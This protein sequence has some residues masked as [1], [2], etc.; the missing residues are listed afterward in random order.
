MKKIVRVVIIVLVVAL[1][2]GAGGLFILPRLTTASAQSSSQN[3][4]TSAATTSDL[5]N[6]VSGT[7]NVRPQQTAL[8][9][10]QTSGSIASV[11]VKQGDTVASGTVLSTLGQAS[12][13]V[14]VFNAQVDLSTAEKDLET[15]LDNT[16]VRADA[17]AALAQAEIDLKTAQDNS[18]AMEF[19]VASQSTIDIAQA[20]LISAQ[21]ALKKAEDNYTK[22][23]HTNT[24]SSDYKMRYANALSQLASA[25]QTVAAAENNL[26][27]LENLPNLRNVALVNA[28]LD[29][30]KA[31]YLE[32]KQA[33]DLVKDG[34]NP[35]TVAAAQAKVA[36]AQAIVNEAQVTAPFAGTITDVYA[37]TGSLVSASTNAFRIQDLSQYLIDVSVSEVDITSVQIG[38]PATITFDAISDKTYTGKVTGIASTG[39]SSSGAVNY[40]VTVAIDNPDSA[41]K[42]GM[43]ASVDIVVKQL[44]GVLVVPNAALTTLNNERVVYV[45]Q[46]NTPVAVPVT[47]G[48][49]SDTTSQVVSG[50]L[51]E[52]D[53]I[54]TNPTSVTTTTTTTTSSGGLFG[55]LLGGLFGGGGVT[56][57]GPSGG[58]GGAPPSGGFP[59]GGPSGSSGGNSS[60]GGN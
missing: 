34:P 19:Q 42:A 23:T 36:A 43:S 12:L 31:T 27:Y 38:N 56:G 57:G 6:T 60:S 15:I 3:Y 39:T 7:G 20:S 25:R 53:L 37:Q 51:K 46:N 41:I 52:G 32:A 9:T 33:W 50:N 13:P 14:A 8:V 58:P 45:L 10:W 16:T 5:T 26:S 29:Q 55:G 35:D 1:V 49:V 30:A 47:L 2:L 4:T 44:T 17:E 54:I 24:T 11:A 48:V 28:E 40:N 18:T 59:S 22:T 21:E